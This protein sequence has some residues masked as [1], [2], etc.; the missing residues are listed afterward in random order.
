M[1]E[2]VIR[3]ENLSSTPWRMDFS[4]LFPAIIKLQVDKAL[5]RY[6]EKRFHF[7]STELKIVI[8]ELNP[9]IQNISYN[10]WEKEITENISLDENRN[11]IFFHLWS[12]NFLALSTRVWNDFKFMDLVDVWFNRFRCI[13]N[14]D[15]SLKIA[16]LWSECFMIEDIYE[17]QYPGLGNIYVSYISDI[18]WNKH[19]GVFLDEKGNILNSNIWWKKLFYTRAWIINSDNWD[20]L[21]E[22]FFE[23]DRSLKIIKFGETDFFT[24]QI[25]KDLKIAIIT[26]TDWVRLWW[27]IWETA[28]V[29]NDECKEVKS[30]EFN[31]LFFALETDIN[32]KNQPNLVC[33]DSSF[34][35]ITNLKIKQIPTDKIESIERQLLGLEVPNKETIEALNEDTSVNRVYGSVND[36]MTDLNSDKN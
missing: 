13:L 18:K 7:G 5:D 14:E 23:N 17:A 28:L 11:P 22:G 25:N 33:F 32:N 3:Q 35:R 4:S 30:V 27:E 34:E 10:N 15:W 26:N 31:W 21:W 2:D 29:L 6:Y 8:D 9:S 16:K 19:R 36:L 20:N 1:F 24:N 12:K